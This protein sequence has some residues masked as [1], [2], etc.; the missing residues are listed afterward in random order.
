MTLL[1]ALCPR[2]TSIMTLLLVLTLF[3]KYGQYACVVG[4][5]IKKNKKM[6]VIK[7]KTTLLDHPDML[8]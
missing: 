8:C 2:I 3:F 5:D 7:L 1:L 4:R 6:N